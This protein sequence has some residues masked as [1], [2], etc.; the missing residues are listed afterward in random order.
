MKRVAFKP[1]AIADLEMIGDYIASQ[2][3]SRAETY[4]DEIRQKALNVG[5]APMAYP[6]RADLGPDFRMTVHGQ[7]LILFRVLE[8]EV[9]IVRIIHGARNLPHALDE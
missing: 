8:Y 7:Y 1:D 6:M 5:A 3:P 9:E 2:N 4:I